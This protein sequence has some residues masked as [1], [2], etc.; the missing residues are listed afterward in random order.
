MALKATCGWK[1]A[2]STALPLPAAL[3]PMAGVA[4][5]SARRREI[6]LLAGEVIHRDGVLKER[7][8]AGDDGNP[9]I[10]DEVARAVGF[11]VV[12]DGGAFREMN[13]AVDDAAADAAVASH[14]DVREQNRGVHLTIRIDAHVGR[15]NGVLD[16]SS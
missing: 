9:A 3:P 4:R 10:G 13:V 16:D 7:V 15:E 11:G 8:V 2:F 14:R 6:A 5:S 1:R 12:A